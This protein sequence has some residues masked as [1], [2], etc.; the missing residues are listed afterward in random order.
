MDLVDKQEVKGVECG[1][2]RK[3]CEIRRPKFDNLIFMGQEAC[4]I[5]QHFVTPHL[6]P[7]R[8]TPLASFMRGLPRVADA[9]VHLRN[10]EERN[11]FPDNGK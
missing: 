2:R 4:I 6:C 11:L 5:M 10:I 3:T 7:A 8:R 1:E 9:F